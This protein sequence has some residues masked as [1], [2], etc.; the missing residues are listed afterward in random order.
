M[1]ENT[2]GRFAAINTN[3]NELGTM[4]Y[5]YGYTLESPQNLCL[6]EAQFGDFYNPAQ[7]M[8]DQYL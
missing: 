1:K 8:I 2:K 5:E 3:L 7:L 6:W 4:A